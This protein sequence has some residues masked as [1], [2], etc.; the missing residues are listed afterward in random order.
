MALKLVLNSSALALLPAVVAA[1]ARSSIFLSKSALDSQI[2]GRASDF[3]SLSLPYGNR[4]WAFLASA[5]MPD[6]RAFTLAASQASL[7]LT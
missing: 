7:P 6:I 4:P 2:F 1:A 3:G 5:A